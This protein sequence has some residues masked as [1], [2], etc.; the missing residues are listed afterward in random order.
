M[1]GKP[2]HTAISQQ[3]M[4]TILEWQ[5]CCIWEMIEHFHCLGRSLQAGSVIITKN[6]LVS[7]S[8]KSSF[9]LV[10]NFLRYRS[11]CVVPSFEKSKQNHDLGYL[12]RQ[13]HM[14]MILITITK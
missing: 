12:N 1:G 2:V 10:N 4:I 9:K 14:I 6:K 5:K 7:K 3:N 11:I 13:L 8:Q